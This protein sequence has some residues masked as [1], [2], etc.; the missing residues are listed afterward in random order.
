MKKTKK[1]YVRPVMM[2]L[3]ALLMAGAA[4]MFSACSGEDDLAQE[5]TAPQVTQTATK[6]HVSV[7]AGINDAT[8][9]SLVV[10]DGSTRTLQFTTGDKLYI[11]GSITPNERVM[12]GLISIKD[13]SA[14][15]LSATFDGD[16]TV[17]EKVNK[18]WEEDKGYTQSGDPMTWYGDNTIDGKLVHA[19]APSGLYQ[20]LWG[21][22]YR[23]QYNKSLMT[24]ETDNVSK[25]MESA[26]HVQGRYNKTDKRFNLNCDDAIFNCTFG[27]LAKNTEYYVRFGY[28]ENVEGYNSLGFTHDC[29]FTQ[30]VT[31]NGDGT[32]RF[33]FGFEKAGDGYYVIQ[34]CT[35]KGFEPEYDDV[36]TCIIGQK[37]IDAKVYNLSR[38]FIYLSILETSYEA[39]D[40]DVLIGILSDYHKI[41]IAAGA[42]VT[43]C[44]ATIPGRTTNE[45]NTPWAGITCLG[46]ATI[47]L[48]D[49]T[50]N[51]VKGYNCYYP[52]IQAGT[53]GTTLTIRG[54]G[55]LTAETGMNT[56]KGKGAGI[57]GGYH[58]TVGNIRIEGGTI[59][60]RGNFGGAGIGSGYA[61]GGTASCGNITITGGNVTAIGG[62][63]AA[64]IGTGYTMRENLAISCTGSCGNI[65]ITGGNVTAIGGKHAAG[66]G[67]GWA[68]S[69]VEENSTASCGNI[70]IS[71][72][73]TGTATGGEGN[74]H[75]I[76]VGKDGTCGTVSVDDGTIEGVAN[77]VV[78]CTFN[79][80][81]K[82]G[83]GDALVNT[84]E[85]SVTGSATA[86]LTNDGNGI[87]PGRSIT[88]NMWTMK[89]GT[90]TF[91]ATCKNIF[92]GGDA[93][94]Y[95][96]TLENVTITKGTN[97]FDV[98]MQQ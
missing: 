70:T 74:L 8:T 61:D 14:D 90:L 6:I 87:V 55:T 42:T 89:S 66:I 52:G 62:K 21:M 51:Y 30:T 1:Q 96:C 88:V 38:S 67:T 17:Y 39:Q 97:T 20:T 95:T 28:A 64:G 16:L 93:G 80:T 3:A 35:S 71:A 54:T 22:S 26:I 9:R 77:A 57:G 15:G 69:G 29:I 12:C 31:T 46:D 73:A 50:E 92:G 85:I 78:P 63:C 84:T 43:L 25:L 81:F 5:P 27:G 10:K 37:N 7:G 58:Q 76:G 34:L 72:P 44:G 48:A 32:A 83:G 18:E 68:D 56:T 53:T 79:I 82:K 2:G 36:H 60:A 40:G 94:T 91:T 4:M 19:D 13:I 33:A 65:T 24:G 86:T 23:F 47:V 98:V 75:D 59:T 41:S 45:E 49:G 11:H